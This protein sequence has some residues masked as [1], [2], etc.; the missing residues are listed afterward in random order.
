MRIAERLIVLAFCL[1]SFSAWSADPRV[2]VVWEDDV[3]VPPDASLLAEV[4]EG[5]GVELMWIRQV[6][7]GASLLKWKGNGYISFEQ[8]LERLTADARIRFVQPD[9]LRSVQFEPNDPFYD[10]D[11]QPL[12]N[13]WYLYEPVGINAPAAWDLQRGS[14]ATIIALLDTGIVSH[15]DLDGARILPGYDFFSDLS[16]DNDGTPGRDNDPTD[17]GDW[18]VADEC[19]PGSL[20]ADSTWHGLS[21]AGVMLASADNG[22]GVAGIDHRARLLPIRVFGKCGAFMSD[23]LDAMAWAAGLAVAGVPTN[24]NP[25]DVI[26]LSFGGAGACGPVEQAA[27]DSVVAAGVVVVASAGNGDGVAS[28]GSGDV[29]LVSPASCAGV[30]TVAA[31]SR[32]GV[33]ASYSKV[34][35]EIDIT[36]AAGDGA[37]EGLWTTINLG[38]TTVGGDGYGAFAGTS[39]SAAQASAVVALMLAVQ[40]QATVE[41]IRQALR[42]SARPFL[43][44]SCTNSLCGAGMLDAAAA[45]PAAQRLPL[46]TAPATV[47]GGGGSGGGCTPSAQAGPDWLL[48]LLLVWFAGRRSG[49]MLTTPA[50][51]VDL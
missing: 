47:A 16:V 7:G 19:S 37:G 4:S 29:A 43:D 24:P 22:A 38:A 15:V 41:Q 1:L 28:I 20:A 8:V 14:S 40:P 25:A 9:Q 36:A 6:A 21:I 42:D 30:I 32:A 45:I 13:Q 51:R 48:L 3:V 12:N 10:D 34:G 50:R 31:V 33:L 35:G 23:I 17:P 2:L 39:Y 18:V 11:P 49:F 44:S 5:A 26:N 46:V 27:I